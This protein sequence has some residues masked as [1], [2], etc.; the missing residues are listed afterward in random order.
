MAMP[1]LG[2]TLDLERS[3]PL[4]GAVQSDAFAWVTAESHQVKNNMWL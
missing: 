3:S 2:V 4:A 1:E